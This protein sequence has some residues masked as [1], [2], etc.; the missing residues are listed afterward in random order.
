MSLALRIAVVAIAGALGA[1]ARWGCYEAVRRW[2]P[3]TYSIAWHAGTLLVNTLGCFIFGLLFEMLKHGLP[4]ESAWRLAIF[5]GFLG[6]FTTY[7]TF[8]FDTHDLHT[9][10]GLTA[11][12]CFIAVQLITGWAALVGGM[13][14][15]RVLSG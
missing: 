14:L 15:G 4:L 12:L 10:R 3:E 9:T 13:F 8:A 7:S 5:T 2:L 11:A 6:A 1:L